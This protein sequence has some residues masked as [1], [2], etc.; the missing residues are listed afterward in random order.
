LYIAEKLIPDVPYLM[1]LQTHLGICP[2]LF[3]NETTNDIFERYYWEKS[4]NKPSFDNIDD[5]PNWWKQIKTIID[6]EILLIEKLKER[7]SQSQ[8]KQ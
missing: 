5:T 8:Q 3:L 6:S 1:L 7:E 2:G 4:Y